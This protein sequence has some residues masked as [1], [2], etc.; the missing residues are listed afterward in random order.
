MVSNTVVN[1]A[2]VVLVNLAVFSW[3][4]CFQFIFESFECWSHDLSEAHLNF[5]G[6]DIEFLLNGLSNGNSLW[7]SCLGDH[8]LLNVL[9]SANDLSIVDNKSGLGLGGSDKG[10]ISKVLH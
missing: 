5:Q 10:K 9:S 2:L 4:K 7:L 3:L 1:Q 6:S 8:R